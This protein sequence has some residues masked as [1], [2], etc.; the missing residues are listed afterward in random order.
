MLIPGSSEVCHVAFYLDDFE[1]MFVTSNFAIKNLSFSLFLFSRI[2]IL[3]KFSHQGYL[4][5]DLF[6]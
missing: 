2:G 6:R 3:L 1:Y 4:E 5:H